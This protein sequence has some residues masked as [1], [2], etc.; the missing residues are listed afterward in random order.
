MKK[1]I[2][3]VGASTVCAFL[4]SMPILA[5]CSLIFP[6]PPFICCLL[7][8]VST[9]ELVLLTMWVYFTYFEGGDE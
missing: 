5:T 9:C 7:V 4:F 2:Q 6:W 1:I 8:F 3:F